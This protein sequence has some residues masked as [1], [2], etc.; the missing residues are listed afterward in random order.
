[1]KSEK[2]LFENKEL[3]WK[4]IYGILMFFMTIALYFMAI[5]MRQDISDINTQLY[6]IRVQVD[7]LENNNRL[8]YNMLLAKRSD[9]GFGF[10][11]GIVKE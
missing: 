6:H 10:I 5:P 1:M 4:L 8:L 7:V 9:G 2:D 11:P 3:F